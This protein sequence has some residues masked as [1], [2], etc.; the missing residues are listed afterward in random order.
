MN[1]ITKI[2]NEAEQLELLAAQRE[3]YSTAKLIYFFQFLGSVIL[4]IIFSV[5]SLFLPTFSIITASYALFFFITDYLFF[6]PR[7]KERKITAAK[8]QE[9]FDCKVLEIRKSPFKNGDDILIEE[10]QDNYEKHT[11]VKNKQIQNWYAN[12]S[13]EITQLPISIARL[14]CQRENMWWDSKLRKRYYGILFI[15]N[16]IILAVIFFTSVKLK[17]GIEQI[18]LI[19]SGLLPLLRFSIKQYADNK[20]SSE[21]LVKMCLYF[22]KMREKLLKDDP[23]EA[24]LNESARYIQN[25]LYDNRTRSPLIP[26]F[27]N[28]WFESKHQSLVNSTTQKLIKEFKQLNVENKEIKLING[29][30]RNSKIR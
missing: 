3:I 21:K 20:E 12:G 30:E 4:P 26:D 9:V 1:Q 15:V 19:C 11:A 10:I 2:Q 17:L 28:Y 16:L 13:E 24:E 7:I 14:I 8:I 18:I 27:F 22:D 29:D 23:S 25:E 6:E 5:I